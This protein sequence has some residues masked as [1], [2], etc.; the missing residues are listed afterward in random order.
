MKVNIF[1]KNNVKRAA[2]SCMALAASFSLYAYDLVEDGISYTILPDRDHCVE[3]SAAERT[4]TNIDI[5]SKVN[6]NGNDYTV[7]S[8]GT[9]ALYFHHTRKLKLPPTLENIGSL[10]LYCILNLE[11]ITIPENVSTMGY[12]CLADSYYFSLIIPDKV[13]IIDG[14][15]DSQ[16]NLHTVVLGR[17]TKEIKSFAFRDVRTLREMYV[18][19]PEPPTLARYPFWHCYSPDA[20]IYVPKEALDKYPVNQPQNAEGKMMSPPFEPTSTD[21]SWTFFHDFRPIPDLFIV[22]GREEYVKGPGNRDYLRS[23]VVNYAGVD[24][25][26]DKWV[27]DPEIVSIDGDI[28][29]ALAP[30]KTT[31]KRVIETSSGTFESHEIKLTVIDP[32]VAGVE[33]PA[34]DPTEQGGMPDYVGSASAEYFTI[35]G[36]PAGSDPDRLAPGIYIERDHGKTRKF[37]KH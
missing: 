9:E 13:E 7:V 4:L 33:L 15:F 21:T 27:Y 12:C 28:F 29:T 2:A 5:P 20:I 16:R 10:G 6:I 34:V 1:N 18:M 35:D 32:D 22:T 26:S 3:V 11:Y 25:L 36:I 14:L 17:N 8:I 30:G 37:I 19:C 23:D 24:I 31:M